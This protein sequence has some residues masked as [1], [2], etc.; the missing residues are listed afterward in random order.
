L[1]ETPSIDAAP[2]EPGKR[3]SWV[4]LYLDL[5]F[6]LAVGQLGHLI[7]AHP[8]MH[9]V[10]VA[11]G[12]FLTLWWTWVGFA[13]LYNRQGADDPR[14][15]LFFL[16]ASVPVG[17]AAV[18]I[19]PASTGDST[20]F[21]LSLA[22]IRLLIAGAH[23]ASRNELNV[24]REQIA[25]ACIA[26]AALFA[27]SALVPAPYRYALWAAGIVVESGAMLSEDRGAARRARHDHDLRA[28]RP[29][30][31]SEAL[32]PHH[33]AERF[34]LFV[35]ILLGELVV[36]AGQASAAGDI[37][38]TGEWAALVAAMLVA[39]AL[40]WLY[41]DS[42][43]EINLKVLELSGG[44]TTIAR[45]IFAVGHMLPAFALLL[46]AAG[47]GLLLGADPPRIAYVLAAVG[48]GIYL[49]GTRVF[50]IASGKLS[51]AARSLLLVA[52]FF[53]GRL[54]SWMTPHEFLWVLAAWVVVCAGLSTRSPA[55][56][57]AA[58]AAIA[59]RI[60]RDPTYAEDR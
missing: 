1:S 10:W 2:V 9:S 8:S 33:F 7:I 51:R 49:L 40:W 5:V 47:V 50:L 46:V 52:T 34:G 16:A 48:T 12:L 24:L 14:Q 30:D 35:I 25:R 20:L 3:V 58:E 29:A 18:A 22:V 43:A 44:S 56:E 59:A 57:A 38:A 32:D 15:R 6:V 45:A 53:L 60:G 26:S 41:F 11:L 13:V 23:A 17:V 21:A 4:E 31:P 36:Q 55:D 37:N 19:D 27:V 42:L 39:A 28:F 54:Y